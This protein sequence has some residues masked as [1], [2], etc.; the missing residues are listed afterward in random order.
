MNVTIFPPAQSRSSVDAK[1]KRT[2]MRIVNLSTAGTVPGRPGVSSP[3]LF[4]VAARKPNRPLPAFSL[5]VPVTPANRDYLRRLRND[6]L[7]VWQEARAGHTPAVRRENT[8]NPQDERRDL[9]AFGLVVTLTML[10]TGVLLGQATVVTG[11]CAHLV[12]YVRHLLG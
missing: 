4:G 2:D 7:R 6:E 5:R 8:G 3:A 9:F 12:S 10:L 11:P 1:T